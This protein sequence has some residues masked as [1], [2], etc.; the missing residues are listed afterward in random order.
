MSNSISLWASKHKK[1]S[2]FLLI[3]NH[4]CLGFIAYGVGLIWSDSIGVAWW[5]ILALYAF[6]FLFYKKNNQ[7]YSKGTLAAHLVIMFLNFCFWTM[8]GVKEAHWAEKEIVNTSKSVTYAKFAAY[9]LAPEHVVPNIDSKQNS[10]N[11]FFSA[12]KKNIL[13]DKAFVKKYLKT[14]PNSDI[15]GRITVIILLLT[16]L[17]LLGIY[18]GWGIACQ[19]S[20]SGYTTGITVTI[21]IGIPTFIFLWVVGVKK[22]NKL[23]A[24]LKKVEAE[25]KRYGRQKAKEGRINKQKTMPKTDTSP[26]TV[27]PIP[28]KKEKKLSKAQQRRLKN[29]DNGVLTVKI[30]TIA[31]LAIL[32]LTMILSS[33]FI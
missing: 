10:E 23:F 1:T 31:V 25:E 28:K 9:T 33:I 32:I 7:P 26:T 11:T 30:I 8:I 20:C 27:T 21:L 2:R 19:I 16:L 6:S 22:L 18:V 4:V 17:T 15:S 14:D 12:W 3:I 13:R 24:E 29:I 5:Q